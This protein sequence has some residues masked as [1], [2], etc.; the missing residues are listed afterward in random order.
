LAQPLL[1]NV[2][3]ATVRRNR[4]F[5]AWNGLRND[6]EIT[7][8]PHYAVGKRAPADAYY[9]KPEIATQSV[10][11][12]FKV[13]AERGVKLNDY[14]FIDPSAGEGCFHRNLPDG[15]SRIALDI[16]PGATRDIVKADFLSWYPEHEGR[17][18][19]IG[20]PP[21]GHRGA[22]ALAFI[23]RA[24]LFADLVGFILPMS[25]YSNGKGS[26]MKR[27]KNA[28]LL[29][30]ERLPEDSFYMPATRETVS[31]NTVF[32][33]WKK[34]AGKSIFTDY[35][36]SEW[37]DVYTCCSIPSRFCGLGRGRNYDCFIASS[38]YGDDIQIVNKFSEVKYGSGY[39][40]IAKREPERVLN[41][42]KSIDWV[43]YSSEATNH[44]RHIRMY[45]IRQ[46]MGELGF[47]T[48]KNAA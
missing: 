37:M 18:A 42:L 17:Y 9:T 19:V 26:N 39:G 12:F 32:Q 34:G 25:F 3:G 36:I 48:V 14:T 21:F 1:L 27:V 38:F 8:L 47:G 11:V 15:L 16:D 23:N 20:N 7:E 4:S 28:T 44:C 40:F 46:A 13:C 6:R 30:S 43:K 33:V 10:S 22:M 2:D 35:D 31:V 29:H 24:F 41:A 45:H 5:S